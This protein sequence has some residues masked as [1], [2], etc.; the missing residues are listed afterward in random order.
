MTMELLLSPANQ[1][2]S[3]FLKPLTHHWRYEDNV[4]ILAADSAFDSADLRTYC[5]EK[6]IALIAVANPRRKK[7]LIKLVFRIAGLSNSLSAVFLGT[8]V[9]KSA[10]QNFLNFISPSFS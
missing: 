10:G 1:H 4:R 9:S 3:Q 6:N 8:V 7:M 2:D 5:K